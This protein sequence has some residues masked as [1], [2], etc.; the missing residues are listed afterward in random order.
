VQAHQLA[1]GQVFGH[2]LLAGAAD[3]VAG[4]H[5]TAQHRQV[6]GLQVRGEVAAPAEVGQALAHAGGEQGT[7][8]RITEQ[9]V[10]RQAV[11]GQQRVAGAAEEQPRARVERLGVKVRV[12]LERADVVD[13]EFDLLAAQGLAQLLGIVHPQRGAD[14]GVAGNEALQ[15]FGHQAHGQGRAAA[16]VQF[17]GVELGHLQHFV[18]QLGGALYQAAGVL[19]HHL[20]FG[21]GRQGFIGAV[22]EGAAKG[23]FEVLDGAAEGRL[24][25]AHGFGGADET[26]VF[27]EGDEVAQLAEVH[28]RALVRGQGSVLAF[29]TY[30]VKE[31]YLIY[32]FFFGI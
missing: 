28:S 10:G 4:Q 22:D 5:H 26:A 18:V 24:G 6:F 3:G 27:G 32:I 7:G 15:G 2:R 12:G 1:C 19:Q 29:V 30:N 8:Q 31:C 14:A 21:G 17:A 13:E 23:L 9:V 11:L 20:A 25:D 16:E